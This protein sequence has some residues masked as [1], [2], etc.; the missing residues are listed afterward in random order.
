[1]VLGLRAR[2]WE[3]TFFYILGIV[4]SAASKVGGSLLV[5]C[6]LTAPAMIGLLLANRLGPAMAIS[7]AAACTATLSG[8][9]LSYTADLPSNQTIIVVHCLLLVVAAIMRLAAPVIPRI[10]RRIHEA[11]EKRD[12][13]H[14]EGLE[15]REVYCAAEAQRNARE[16]GE[17]NS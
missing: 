9:H 4:V 10:R 3:L 2:A 16:G 13:L 12:C 8:L 14:H 6:Y 15:E 11:R 7:V 17:E 1:M 5:F